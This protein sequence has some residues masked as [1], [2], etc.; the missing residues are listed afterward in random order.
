ML[1]KVSTNANR[2]LI[3]SP[4]ETSDP[5]AEYERIKGRILRAFVITLAFAAPVIG[6]WYIEVG[7]WSEF[8]ALQLLTFGGLVGTLFYERKKRFASAGHFLCGSLVVIVGFIDFVTIG[9]GFPLPFILMILP[10]IGGM[11]GGQRSA[12]GWGMLAV[13]AVVINYVVVLNGFEGSLYSPEPA[14]HSWFELLS[15]IIGIGSCFALVLGPIVLE[16]DLMHRF[17]RAKEDA[18]AANAEKGRYLAGVS[19]EARNAVGAIR[20][21]LEVPPSERQNRNDE[22]MSMID[23]CVSDSLHLFDGLLQHA[24]LAERKV[25]VN[26]QSVLL[27]ELVNLLRAWAQPLA[28]ESGLELAINSSDDEVRIDRILFTRVA[29]NLLRNALKFSNSGAV[30]VSLSAKAGRLELVVSDQGQGIPEDQ[31]ESIFNDWNRGDQQH[32]IPGAGLGLAI[33]KSLVTL[34]GGEI[35]VQSEVGV[36]TCFTVTLPV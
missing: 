35:S 33:C 9:P 26:R 17:I 24:Q 30:S 5:L 22:V 6:S 4:R 7:A 16:R 28:R 18:E 32:S 29:N 34:M 10:L 3:P 2:G 20:M 1:D 27:S 14:L 13:I 21:L 31:L 36:G 25:E 12:L 8:I 19:H 23:H 15:V 11:T